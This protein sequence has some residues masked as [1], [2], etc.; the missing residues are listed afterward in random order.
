MN[1]LS[2]ND[3]DS[4][5]DP[6]DQHYKITNKEFYQITKTA[7]LEDFKQQQQKWIAHAT[8]KENTDIINMLI[9]HTTLNKTFG[10]KLPSILE[11]EIAVSELEKSNFLKNCL[12]KDFIN[13]NRQQY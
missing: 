11:R 3:N 9:L 5:S 6:V 13:F 1:P 12:K 4:S 7:S 10:R 8:K 2:L